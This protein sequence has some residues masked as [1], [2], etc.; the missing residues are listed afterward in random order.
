MT[1]PVPRTDTVSTI[2]RLRLD[3]A[4]TG[5]PYTI[6]PVVQI[7]AFSAG[8]ERVRRHAKSACSTQ[9]LP[10]LREHALNQ[11]LKSIALSGTVAGITSTLALALM[12]RLEGKGA[13]QPVNSTSHWL[14]GEQ[15]ASFKAADGSH[16][17][18]GLATNQA[19]TF[20]WAALFEWWISRRRPLSP[21]PMFGHALAASAVAAA[22]D[23]G[24]TPKRFT[25]GWEFVLTK[26]SMAVAYIAMAVGMAAGALIVQ[27]AGKSIKAL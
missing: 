4:K 13:L 11:S 3:H 5:L 17:A 7:Y 12:A 24:A 8:L 9:T 20:F 10:M 21:L 15:A 2:L 14:N 26:R 18:V 19:A 25:P 16:T 22:V 6:A 1:T 27:P 23:Y